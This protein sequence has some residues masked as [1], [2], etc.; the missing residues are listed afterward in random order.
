MPQIVT[1]HEYP[2]IPDRRWD[3]GA[4]GDNYCGEGSPIGWG[5]TREAAVKEYLLEVSDDELEEIRY[6]M[7]THGDSAEW[8]DLVLAEQAS[9]KE[10]GP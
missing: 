2:P 5:P 7:V 8:L 1:W 6:S 4:H 3:W 10:D 9:R